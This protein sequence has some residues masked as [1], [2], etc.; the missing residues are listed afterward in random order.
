MSFTALP[1]NLSGEIK[2]IWG[3]LEI[4]Y[5]NPSAAEPRIEPNDSNLLNNIDNF[6]SFILFQKFIILH[7]LQFS[8][9]NQIAQIK[10]TLKILVDFC[11]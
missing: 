9:T 3:G 11:L 4:T 2:Q 1:L 10:S 5:V 8:R 6:F 7:K